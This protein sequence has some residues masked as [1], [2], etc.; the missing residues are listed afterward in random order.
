MAFPLQLL[1]TGYSGAA[2]YEQRPDGWESI[3][4]EEGGA[5]SFA[6]RAGSL[7]I[8]GQ[9]QPQGGFLG[10]YQKEPQGLRLLNRVPT[11]GG[12]LCHLAW[13]PA[14][15][16]LYGSCYETG[17]ILTAELSPEGQVLRLEALEEPES[18]LSRTHCCTL[19]PEGRYVYGVNIA[20]DRIY[21][22]RAVS[23]GL[24]PEGE[25]L[26]LPA[27][28]G[29]RHLCFHPALP[30]ACLIT[31]YTSRIWLLSYEPDTGR[32]R[33]EGQVS[34]L[35]EGFSGESYGSGILF[36]PDGR[37]LYA[38]NRGAD[39]AAVFALEDGALRKVQDAS[40]GGNWPR[41]LNLGGDWL[42]TA[43]QRSYR[44]DALRLDGDGLI[45]G[46]DFSIPFSHPSYT[47]LFV[48]V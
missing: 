6:C 18:S 30:L 42:L 32:L 10:I 41:H 25:F 39:T 8:T 28:E 43:N 29:P 44:V 17:H 3:W 31:E 33:A 4:Q 14:C 35:P 26:Q 1:I 5:P 27:G 37:R 11:P 38:G 13:N 34:A 36:S 45:A 12:G 47:E 7:V 22:Y 46:V 23:G 40:C 16:T 9:E 15:R 20:R 2:L 48:S 21:R 19:S 24:E